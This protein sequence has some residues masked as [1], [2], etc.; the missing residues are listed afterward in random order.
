MRV[1]KDSKLISPSNLNHVNNAVNLKIYHRVNWSC[2][3]LT[4]V[5]IEES[6]EY[7]CPF[8]LHQQTFYF[9]NFASMC[10]TFYLDTWIKYTRNWRLSNSMFYQLCLQFKA[11]WGV[12]DCHHGPW[13][14]SHRKNEEFFRQS[15]Q[16]LNVASS[17]WR[18]K[19]GL[20]HTGDEL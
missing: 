9:N 17:G 12:I 10:S 19:V 14:V 8:N 3:R 13:N 16:L 6:H 7:E 5:E 1:K 11:F 20:P 15:S 4:T 2:C 18:L